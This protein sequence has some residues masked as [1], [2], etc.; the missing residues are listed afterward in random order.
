MAN[1]IQNLTFDSDSVMVEGQQVLHYRVDHKV[2][3]AKCLEIITILNVLFEINRC[4]LNQV[5]MAGLK[6]IFCKIYSLLCYIVMHASDV[7]IMSDN[8]L[9]IQG[10]PSWMTIGV[11]SINYVNNAILFE[12]S[13]IYENRF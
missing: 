5:E 1:A 8:T 13:W 6:R 12:L 3:T 7:T 2:F 4:E 10:I 11:K 9:K